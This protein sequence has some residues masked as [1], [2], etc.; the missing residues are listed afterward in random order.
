MTSTNC[1]SL[2]RVCMA[3]A[4]AVMVM[5]TVAHAQFR[6]PIVR[7]AVADSIPDGFR[8]DLLRA[9][10]ASEAT[11]RI[12]TVLLQRQNWDFGEIRI[13]D[14]VD[15]LRK[16]FQLPVVLD[17]PALQ[18]EGIDPSSPIGDVRGN[19]TLNRFLELALFPLQVTHF[20][21]DDVV[22]VTSKAKAEEYSTLKIY[23]VLDLVRRDDADDY[24][25]LM[26]VIQ[27]AT[28]GVWEQVDGVGGTI[29]PL[30]ATGSLVIRQAWR[31]HREIE[32]L[33]FTARKVRRLQQLPCF[34]LELGSP[35]S[36]AVGTAVIM[37]DEF[38]T[39]TRTE[40]VIPA[41]SPSKTAAAWQIP[42]V[43]RPGTSRK[44]Q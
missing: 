6:Q 13:E 10:G 41:A 9:S 5:D 20:I 24:S 33:L 18:D 30:P 1:G 34:A 31:V 14:V 15:L 4:I 35:S 21:E 29:T 39:K 44:L 12:E 17:T 32:G 7:S 36:I 22:I 16:Q 23:P 37:G 8:L 3:V 27:E 28:S 38:T 25:S 2:A 26:T 19:M 42:R 11:Q 40:S 43:D